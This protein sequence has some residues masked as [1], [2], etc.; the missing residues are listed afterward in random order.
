MNNK[1]F[2]VSMIL[3]SIMALLVFV[4]LL[5][6]GVNAANAKNQDNMSNAIKDKLSP[7]VDNSGKDEDDDDEEVEETED[8]K[9]DFCEASVG[10]VIASFDYT[11]KIQN[12]TIPCDGTYKLVVAGA[13]GGTSS[14]GYVG[15]KGGVSLGYES[16]STGDSLYVVVGGKGTSSSDAI[17]TENYGSNY[18][19][20]QMLGGY[21]GGGSNIGF[22]YGDESNKGA[23]GGGATHIA[24]LSG[25]L[26]ELRDKKDAV[27]IV[28]GGGGGAAANQ[29]GSAGGGFIGDSINGTAGG[30]Q[31]IVGQP[32]TMNTLFDYSGGFG[33]GISVNSCVNFVKNM[34]LILEGN[35]ETLS[36][37]T[38]GGGYYGGSFGASIKDGG[39]S[40]YQ[41]GG[42]G[43]SGYI[44]G[45]INGAMYN[46]LNSGNGY[47]QI[48]LVSLKK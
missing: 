18:H 43:G 41:Y 6:L 35:E 33:S 16:F 47:A 21:N 39:G 31:S 27:L 19:C 14:K 9:I 20:F 5:I 13:Q 22:G 40:S 24:T 34:D 45:V 11:G 1:G 26:Y 15:G 46:G 3:Y 30:T 4:M 2:A 32:V 42:G 28:A 36:G 7:I 44:G 8:E 23:A 29:A 48:I 12:Y 38:G 25:L 37:G 10:K 17:I